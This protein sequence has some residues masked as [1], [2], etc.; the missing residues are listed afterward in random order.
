[1][2]HLFNYSFEQKLKKI[3]EILNKVLRITYD[4]YDD[5]DDDDDDDD[6]ELFLWYG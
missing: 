2:S 3:N 5:D 4:D 1:M 6:E